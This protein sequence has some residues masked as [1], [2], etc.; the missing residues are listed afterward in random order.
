MVEVFVYDGV[1]RRNFNE[2][3]AHCQVNS[4]VY[5]IKIILE[6]FK[7]FKKIPMVRGSEICLINNI[8]AENHLE[9]ELNFVKIRQLILMVIIP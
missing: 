6:I 9:R 2:E 5:F 8:P 4:D 1:I 3:D 7:D